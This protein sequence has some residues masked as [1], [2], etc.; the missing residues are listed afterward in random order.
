ML[1]N[2]NLR[3]DIQSF[4]FFVYFEML[5]GWYVMVQSFKADE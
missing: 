5:Y 4:D 3:R 2:V 1:G